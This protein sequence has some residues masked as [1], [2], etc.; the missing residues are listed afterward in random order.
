MFSNI[1]NILESSVILKISI[2]YQKIFEIFFL[3]RNLQSHL[4]CNNSNNIYFVERVRQR[5]S[6]N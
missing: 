1:S 2:V 6:I 5:V 3:E 4:Y